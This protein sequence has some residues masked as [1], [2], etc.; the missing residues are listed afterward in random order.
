MN[1][2]VKNTINTIFTDLVQ[3]LDL[4]LNGTTIARLYG[5]VPRTLRYTVSRQSTVE[6]LESRPQSVAWHI[7]IC[8]LP[9]QSSFIAFNDL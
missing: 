1:A 7:G 4:H 6:N 9:S 5:K 2:K 8:H 3:R